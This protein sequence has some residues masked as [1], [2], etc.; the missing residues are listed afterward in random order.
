VSKDQTHVL[1]ISVDGWLSWVNEGNGVTLNELAQL[2]AALHCYSSVVFDGGGST[3]MVKRTA[4]SLHVVNR[5]PHWFGQRPVSDALL[6][7]SR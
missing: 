1:L 4:G 7:F 6:V 3:T 2:T 5:V